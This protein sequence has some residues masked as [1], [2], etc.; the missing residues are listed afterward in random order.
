MARY[1]ELRQ[2]VVGGRGVPSP[3]GPA[4]FLREG[5]RAWMDAWLACPASLHARPE[6]PSAPAE[7][8]LLAS[9]PRELVEL[10]ADMALAQIQG[11]AA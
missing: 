2:E 1:E 11:E 3:L 4:L 10:L 7:S 5:M 9:A 6:T 8:E